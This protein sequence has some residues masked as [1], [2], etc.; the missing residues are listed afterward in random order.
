MLINFG[1]ILTHP[2]VQTSVLASFCKFISEV[3]CQIQGKQ[4]AMRAN[5]NTKFEIDCSEEQEASDTID[6]KFIL[7]LPQDSRDRVLKF[8]VG[9]NYVCI[10]DDALFSD[11][12]SAVCDVV[13]WSQDSQV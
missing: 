3:Y 8:S 6:G 11:L 7:R 10:Q 13:E 9:D 1:L 12:E 4:S 2:C 5:P